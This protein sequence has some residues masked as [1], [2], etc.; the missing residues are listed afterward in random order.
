MEHGRCV[1]AAD[2]RTGEG[3]SDFY[4]DLF[5][6]AQDKT[7]FSGDFDFDFDFD[8]AVTREC[9]VFGEENNNVP[10][11]PEHSPIAQNRCASMH[12]A[13]VLQRG[14]FVSSSTVPLLVGVTCRG[15]LFK[16]G[17]PCFL[18]AERI[19]GHLRLCLHHQCTFR[20]LEQKR[21]PAANSIF[22]AICPSL[23]YIFS[24]SLPATRQ[25]MPI[26][27]PKTQTQLQ[28]LE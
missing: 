23:P 5:W 1:D 2:A 22:G 15:S 25:F 10:N 4:Q 11:Y 9:N 6:P 12:M 26:A 3:Q 17:G 27:P 7:R 14:S 24:R 16:V 8:Y 19:C 20:Y 13:V 28:N 18:G 21:F